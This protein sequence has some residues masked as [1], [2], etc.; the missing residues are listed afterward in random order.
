MLRVAFMVPFLLNV[1]RIAVPMYHCV[2]VLSMYHS[3]CE[4]VTLCYGKHPK[5]G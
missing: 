3:T 2:L 5:Q 1:P 4:H